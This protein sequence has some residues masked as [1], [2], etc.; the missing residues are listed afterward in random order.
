MGQELE[1]DA[2]LLQDYLT[3]CDELLQHLDQ[4]LVTLE[5]EPAIRN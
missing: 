1:L 3:E 2:A 5:G 4:D